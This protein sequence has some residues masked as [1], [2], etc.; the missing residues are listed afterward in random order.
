MATTALVVDRETSL[1]ESLGLTEQQLRQQA[2]ESFLR[3]KKREILQYRLEI[4]ARYGAQ[5][6]E[7]LEALIARGAV[8]EHPAW[9]DLISAENLGAR[10]EELD[11]H[12]QH[13][14]DA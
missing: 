2:L 7:D 8:A 11:G 6:L 12:L 1:A 4:L 3:D 14:Q 9:E 5:S 10:L 13:L